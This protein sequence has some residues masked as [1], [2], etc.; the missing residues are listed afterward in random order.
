MIRIGY[1]ADGPW[2]HAAFEKVKADR[3]FNIVF[4]CVRNDSHDEKHKNYCQQYN[5]PHLK[6]ANVNSEEFISQLKSYTVDLFV[7]MFFNQIFKKE[8]INIPRLKTINCHAGKLPIY[9]GRN[10]LNWGLINDEKEYGVAVHFVDEGIDTGDIILQRTYPITGKDT[11]QT[12]LAQAL[13]ACA[14]VLFEAMTMKTA[15]DL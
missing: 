6:N 14:D 11:Y 13:N 3:R 7:S 12:L 9:R 8:L 5:I 2:S 4:I 10:I 1:F 15:S